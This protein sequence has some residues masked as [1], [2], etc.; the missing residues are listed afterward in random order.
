MKI[1]FAFSIIFLVLFSGC[2]KTVPDTSTPIATYS[3]GNGEGCTGATLSGRF[4][5]DTSLTG[6]NTVTITV[7]VTLAGPYWISTNTVNGMSFSAVSTFTA[8]GPQTAV[9]TATGTP[10][11]LVTANFIL[12][13]LNGL[14]D[15]CTFSVTTVKGIPPQHF[16]TCIINGVYRDFSDSSV[17]SNSGTPGTSGAAGLDIRGLDTVVNSLSKIEFG[18]N[19]T[20]SVGTGTYTDTNAPNAYFNYTD[21][22]GQKWSVIG[23]TQP[24]LT[25]VVTNLNGNNVQGTFSGTIKNQR[26]TDSLTVANGMF[27]V[28]VK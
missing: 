28:P 4:V 18:I 26:A 24:S 16:V 11:S 15:S 13:A 10:I 14:G 22:L 17:A 2:K 1:L 6:A 23:D 27:S 25:I 21:S 9:L 7:D 8:I 12:T 5:K 19:N 20:V 3:L